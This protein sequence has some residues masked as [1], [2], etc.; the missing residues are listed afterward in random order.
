MESSFSFHHFGVA[1][2]SFE[3]AVNFYSNLQYS[4]SEP[5]I[6]ELQNVELVMCNSS[7]FPSVELVRPI[8]EKSPINNYL[9]LNN[10]GIYHTCYEVLKSDFDLSNIFGNI[11]YRCVSNPKPAILFNN[12]SV[13]F[14]YINGVGLVEILMRK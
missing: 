13:A 10:E 8:N 14:Y 11:N 4:I 1:L 6:D 5:I 3:K 2:K 7:F 9:K 12:R